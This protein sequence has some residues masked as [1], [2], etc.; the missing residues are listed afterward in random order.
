MFSEGKPQYGGYCFQHKN[1]KTP[2]KGNS[3]PIRRIKPKPLPKRPAKSVGKNSIKPKSPKRSLPILPMDMMSEI[4][5][6]MDPET[7]VKTCASSKDKTI[8]NDKFWKL[9]LKRDF[10]ITYGEPA[11]LF[12]GPLQ[13]YVKIAKSYNALEK[14]FDLKIKSD[15]VFVIH[16]DKHTKTNLGDV[17]EPFIESLKKGNNIF[18]EFPSVM[19]D[20]RP[21]INYKGKYDLYDF[22][23]GTIADNLSKKSLLLDIT[24]AKVLFPYTK[25]HKKKKDK[26]Y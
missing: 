8:C 10:G 3:P 14:K 25:H 11:F 13:F 21:S 22:V 12:A 23:Y 19:L 16:I 6:H 4:Y 24:Q 20:V 5:L 1:C 7:V 17:E 15:G 2:F 18:L 26:K 9:K